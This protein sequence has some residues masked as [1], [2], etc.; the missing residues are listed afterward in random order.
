MTPLCPA[1][2]VKTLS[3]AVS[4]EN[5][6]APQLI[7]TTETPGNWLAKLTALNR[8]FRSGWA[9]T[10]T[11]LAAGAI[12]CAHSTSSA[13]SSAQ[14]ELFAA[15]PVL[16]VLRERRRG[17]QSV[18]GVELVRGRTL[19]LGSKYASMIAIV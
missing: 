15:Q 6:P 7:E 14:P 18:L 9:S 3:Y 13:V 11:M 19:M 12:A 5:S 1:G 10:R 17:R 8:S 2:V 4:P 16:D